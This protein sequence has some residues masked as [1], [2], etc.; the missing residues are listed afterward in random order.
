MKVH[1]NLAVAPTRRERYALAWAVPTLVVAL[2][3]LV[4]LAASAIRDFRHLHQ[5]HRELAA[6]QA[7][8]SELRAQET[9]VRLELARPKFRQMI[10]ETEFVNQ[11]INQRQFSLTE[12]TV[13]VSKLLPYDVKLSGLG[14]AG[15]DSQPE[16]RFAV[17][18]KS[19]QAIESFLSNLENS[20]DFSDVTIKNQG[21][22]GG[23]GSGPE[24]VVLTCTARYLTATSPA[25]Q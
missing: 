5:V 15:S 22:R 16:V 21:F 10:H 8:D 1:L 17:L 12:L 9:Q 11:L 23:A 7:K 18:G 6:V 25:G 3:V 14:L 20:K 2:L 4:Y 24:Q 13:K 19:E